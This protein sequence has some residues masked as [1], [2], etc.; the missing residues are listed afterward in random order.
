MP[1]ILSGLVARDELKKALVAKIAALQE[2]RGMPITLA[3][4]QVGDRPD[5]TAYINAKKRFAATI[6]VLVRLVHFNESAGQEEIVAAIKALNA[7]KQVSGIIVQLPLPEHFDEQAVLDAI[8][9]AKDTDA[10]STARVKVWSVQRS[11]LCINQDPILYP[12]TARGVGEL[13]D[14]YHISLRDKRVCVIGR[15]NFVGTPIAALCRARGAH[16]TVC[17]SKTVDLVKETLAADVII[18]A[19]GRAGL[20]TAQHVKAGQVVIDVGINEIFDQKAGEHGHEKT[21]R[22]IR[23]LVGDVDFKEASSALGD[24]STGEKGAI[25]PV[26]GGVG[27]MTVLG[28]FENLA[29][30]ATIELSVG[31]S[32]SRS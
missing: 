5:S 2:K 15:S 31:V 30:C 4:I 1:T 32:V 28:L 24:S 19:V 22:P 29:D 25:S 8:D 10:I 12:A 16:V 7:E 27:P 6:G 20:I 17:H 26:P 9:P 23:H 14:F 18:S 21:D 13:L 11:D 3:I